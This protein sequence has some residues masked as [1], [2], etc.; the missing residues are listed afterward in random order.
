MSKMKPVTDILDTWDMLSA[1]RE[2]VQDEQ[3]SL[4]GD[5]DRE[6]WGRLRMLQ[7]APRLSGNVS[8]TGHFFSVLQA[9]FL[10]LEEA[11]WK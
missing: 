2:R 8:Q 4:R 3:P 9:F 10:N 7:H 1:H 11:V 6:G 5:S